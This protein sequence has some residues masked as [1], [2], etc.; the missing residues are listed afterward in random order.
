MVILIAKT[1]KIPCWR[2]SRRL[3]SLAFT[4]GKLYSIEEIQIDW[5]FL[6]AGKLHPW[7]QE[8]RKGRTERTYEP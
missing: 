3:L 1:L 5:Q 6:L 7:L 2:Q 8:G 4:E